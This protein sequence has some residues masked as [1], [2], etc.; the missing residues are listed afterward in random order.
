MI[1]DMDRPDPPKEGQPDP[2]ADERVDIGATYE[3]AGATDG[4]GGDDG[5]RGVIRGDV[6]ASYEIVGDVYTEC[7][8]HHEPQLYDFIFS[9]RHCKHLVMDIILFVRDTVL[10]YIHTC[11]NHCSY[12]I[13][14]MDIVY[15]IVISFY[16][17]LAGFSL[18]HV[19]GF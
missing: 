12:S 5:G 4:I 7:L 11:G 8:I 18:L 15:H 14:D 9:A 17:V 1:D 6:G 19:N 2:A 16:R 10:F 13:M 3:G